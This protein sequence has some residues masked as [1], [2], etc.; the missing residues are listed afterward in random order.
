MQL[1]SA[2]QRHQGHAVRRCVRDIR[3]R[4]PFPRPDPFPPRPPPPFITGL[5]GRFIGTMSP[6]DSS[7]VVR[8][9]KEAAW[10]LQPHMNAGRMKI[11]TFNTGH[12]TLNYAV[13]WFVM[14][15]T[16]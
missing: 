2:G 10:T 11:A 1:R 8:R 4:L 5:F 16:G 15:S 7:S 3:C 12:E 9:A 14:R 6:S 13:E